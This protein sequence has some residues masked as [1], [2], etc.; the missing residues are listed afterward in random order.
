MMSNSI[1]CFQTMVRLTLYEGFCFIP[2][3]IVFHSHI[4]YV[5]VDCFIGGNIFCD[6][7]LKEYCY[8]SFQTNFMTNVESK[9]L[10]KMI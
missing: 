8:F 10:C 2:T 7:Y 5:I 6:I 1:K 4:L 9:N 3:L